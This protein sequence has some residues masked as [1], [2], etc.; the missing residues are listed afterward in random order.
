GGATTGGPASRI[1]HMQNTNPAAAAALPAASSLNSTRT[2]K[3]PRPHYRRHAGL[4]IIGT[5][6]PLT[7]SSVTRECG[8]NWTAFVHLFRSRVW[9]KTG[10]SG[11]FSR[12]SIGAGTGTESSCGFDLGFLLLTEPPPEVAT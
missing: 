10:I 6:T 2:K 1:N 8:Q 9:L 3:S 4:P 7:S 5:P 11:D 12:E